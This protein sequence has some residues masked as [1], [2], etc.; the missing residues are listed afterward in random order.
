MPV[1]LACR[2][3]DPDVKHAV[4][5]LQALVGSLLQERSEARTDAEEAAQLLLSQ[6]CALPCTCC[7]VGSF[8]ADCQGVDVKRKAPVS[9]YAS[10]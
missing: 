7:S 4:Q 2:A 3:A 6:Q 1:Q 8:A 10:P 9:V 5:A